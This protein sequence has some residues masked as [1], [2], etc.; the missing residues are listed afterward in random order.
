MCS[1]R[2][3]VVSFSFAVISYVAHRPALCEVAVVVVVVVV[4]VVGFGRFLRLS[5][6]IVVIVG[7]GRFLRGSA[8]VVVIIACFFGLLAFYAYLRLAVGTGG[9]CSGHVGVAES[10]R[11][12]SLSK[13]INASRA[14][15]RLG[16]G[17]R[18]RLCFTVALASIVVAFA[19][20]F[21]FSGSGLDSQIRVDSRGRIAESKI[22]KSGKSANP[23]CCRRCLS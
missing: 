7:P 15:S 14:G 6:V 4:V 16:A 23:R 13:E 22:C 8:V 5:A 3:H 21:A 17:H 18:S 1:R 20:I 2:T 11:A 19:L 10:L 9:S 12:R